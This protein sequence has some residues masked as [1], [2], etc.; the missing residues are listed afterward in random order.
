MTQKTAIHEVT[1][2]NFP[3]LVMENSRKGLVVVNFGSPAAAPCRLTLDRLS[4]MVTEYGGR[5]LLVHVNIDAQAA[6]ARQRDVQSL[7]TM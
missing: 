7:P 5:F 6:L 3:V 2:G 4:R 1:T